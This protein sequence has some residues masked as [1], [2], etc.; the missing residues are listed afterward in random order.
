MRARISSMVPQ[1]APSLPD[2]E[3][4]RPYVATGREAA[5][6]HRNPVRFKFELVLFRFQGSFDSVAV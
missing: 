1:E 4:I 3:F 2:T 5:E 6:V